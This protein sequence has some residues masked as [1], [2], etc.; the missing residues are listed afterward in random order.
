[1]IHTDVHTRCEAGFF[2]SVTAIIDQSD[3]A[4]V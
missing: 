4:V 1:M 3:M 2:F